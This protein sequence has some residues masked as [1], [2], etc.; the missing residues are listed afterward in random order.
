MLIKY[1]ESSEIHQRR[2]VELEENVVDCMS[3]NLNVN[4]FIEDFHIWI[5]GTDWLASM[6]EYPVFCYDRPTIV[7]SNTTKVKVVEPFS[8]GNYLKIFNLQ[9]SGKGNR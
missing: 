7:A 9:R 6:N 1:H 2:H 5:K 4:K 3:R 8:S